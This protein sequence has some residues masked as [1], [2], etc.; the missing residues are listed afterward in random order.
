MLTA[1][2]KRGLAAGLLA[3]LAYGAYTVLVAS[4]LVALAETF[5]AGTHGHE[6]GHLAALTGDAVTF[7]AGAAWGLLFGALFGVAYY[8]LEPALPERGGYVL[9]GA[10]FLTVS[11]AP[12]LALP[13]VAPGAEH[14]LGTDARLAIYI[15]MMG[16][17]ALAA[18]G[19]FLTYR[20]VRSRGR[21]P[22]AFAATVP[23]L[24][25]LGIATLAPANPTTSPAPAALTAAFRGVAVVGQVSLWA[26]I[27]LAHGGL[28]ELTADAVAVSDVDPVTAD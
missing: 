5:E 22:A 11:G 12:W 13:P 24:A 1:H 7:A 6:V 23:L 3:G 28:D 2:L 14:A 17:G 21:G 27:A 18:A 15:G 25:L 4:P 10:G 16:A 8:L 20:R 9:A 26:V 19:A